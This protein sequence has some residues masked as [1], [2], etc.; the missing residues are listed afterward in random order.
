MIWNLLSNA[1]K[2]TPKQGRVEISL[3]RVGSEAQIKISDTGQGIAPE[4]LP[5]VF[6]RFRQADASSTR[7]HTGLGLGL[8][9]VRHLVELH[10]GTV[11]AESD[12]ANQGATFVI[13]LPLAAVL[14]TNKETLLE[15]RAAA[16]GNKSKLECPPELEGLRV[17]VVDDEEDARELIAVVLEKCGADVTA[18]ESV[19][20]ALV[21]IEKRKP[22]VIVS[23]IGMPGEDG[24]AFIERVREGEAARGER[25]TPA[26]A[27]TAFARAED[28]MRV[29]RSGFQIHIPKPVEPA[30]LVTVV[31]NL[32]GRNRKRE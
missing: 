6:D 14:T 21:E 7:A 5:H 3:D 32:A 11:R 8:A 9:I 1:I 15:V 19:R 26:A 16:L 12:G 30:E 31:V 2:F 20:A 29:L 24:Y 4:F 13:S 17:L 27:L 10:G 25:E 23:D 18:V 28:R 22:D